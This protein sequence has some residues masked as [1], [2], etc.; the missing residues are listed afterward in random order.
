MTGDQS[1]L[2]RIN[3]MALV[4]L[5]KAEPGLSRVDLANRTGLTKTTVGMLVQ[6]LIDEGWLHQNAPAEGQ[7]VGRRPLP[8][9][10]DR[11]RIALVG[12]E[13]G[14]DYLNVVA[15]NLQGA[16][17]HSK[18]IP[19]HHRD[20]TRSLRTLAS[21]LARA[22]ADLVA[23]GR[24][25]LGIGLGVPGMVDLQDGTLRFAPNIGWHGVR[26]EPML[27]A[28]LIEAGCGDLP[29]TV[30][31]DAKAAALSEYVFG[32]EHHTGPLIYL[33]IGI[34]LGG[35]IVLSDRLYLGHDG[36]AGEVGHTILQRGGP[37]CA[38][39]RHGC[40]EMFISQ[41][42]V[43][44]DLTGKDNPVLTLEAIRRALADGDKA[45]FRAARRAGEYLGVLLQNL[46][47]CYNPAVI[48][49]GGPLVQLGDPLIQPA[50]ASMEA[51]A[52]KFDF[53]RQ[54]V[55]LCRFGIDACALGAAAGVFQR[56][57]YSVEA[58]LGA[59][60]GRAAGSRRRVRATM[61]A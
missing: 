22:H 52:G 31:N 36:I 19:Y 50:L 35:G 9:T 4:R 40:A 34:G 32:A 8:L 7:G 2:K 24:R 47:N 44:R 60:P 42:A 12:A 14:V 6:E 41:R 20:V 3:R 29:V 11:D 5:V 27:T 26:I 17:F 30:S 21:M 28:R 55:R 39:G 23:E 13:I 45:A 58:D 59:A 10:L 61:G 16:I 48:V 33:A 38:C 43:S 18:C 49:L 57:L 37:R 25:V 46:A 51:H 15:C 54:S 56:A 53:H 1:L